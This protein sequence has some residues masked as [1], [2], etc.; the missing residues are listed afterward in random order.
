MYC[1]KCGTPNDD[2][3]YR[4]INCSG[5]IQDPPV[6]NKDIAQDAGLRMLLPIGR[7]VFAVIAGYLGLFSVLM[8]PAPFA[9]I[10]G[11]IGI[12]DIKRNPQ[13]HG[14]GRAIFGIIMGIIF[15]IPVVIL[16]IA[17]FHE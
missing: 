9:L 6:Q 3:A 7:S 2:N 15:S 12:I 14:M 8:I 13:K 5:I 17:Y 10:L 16:I 4:C 11:I 1:P